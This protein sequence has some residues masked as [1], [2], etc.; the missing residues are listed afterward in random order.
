[1]ISKS[2][3][4]GLLTFSLTLTSCANI[5][6]LSENNT[7]NT[8]SAKTPTAIMNQFVEVE[9]E[10]DMQNI[11]HQ[12]TLV[13]RPAFLRPVN[14]E[15]VQ[16]W[17]KYFS[18]RGK[19]HFERYMK[20][21]E[22][23]RP[24]IEEIFEDYGL[25]RELYFVGLIESGYHLHAKSIASA[26]GPWQFIKST[27]LRYGLKVQHGIDE[28]RNIVKAT[29]AAALFF[30]DLYNIFGSWEL[31]LSAYNAGE[32]GVI[33]RIRGA[34]T[35]D[36]YEL[37]EMKKLPKETRHYV[38]KVLAAMEV[39]NNHKKYGV[40]HPNITSTF[41]KNTDV[42]KIRQSVDV[43]W[44]SNKLGVDLNTFKELNP[45]ILSSAIPYIPKHGISIRIPKGK[46]ST[47]LASMKTYKERQND[48]IGTYKI[49]SGDNLIEIAR[50]FN[51]SVGELK[52]LNQM[53]RNTIYTGQKLRVPSSV[54]SQ[55]SIDQDTTE[56]EKYK[57]K[58][59][60]NLYSIAR[61]YHTSLSEILKLNGTRNKNIFIGQTIKVPKIDRTYYIVKQGD[62]LEKIAKHHG[63]SVQ[64]I[65][66]LNTMNNSRI[67][68][69]QRLIVKLN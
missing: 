66:N 24:L 18:T 64:Q 17:I 39:Y 3:L 19:G 60:D 57:V 47:L 51:I 45:E 53:S 42:V 40:T 63:V 33:R 61:R 35:R 36:F 14:N 10:K 4:S 22:K 68:P 67:F 7:R 55:N 48:N 49:K 2:K 37:S 58:R 15:V 11:L 34:K 25:P 30:Q 20:N 65:K 38:P 31:A 13:E 6:T 28:R 54:A 43:K 9:R 16:M 59:G 52:M 12:K 50:K 69:G 27:G 29:K 1:M 21:G 23:Y 46:E 41:Y 5:R 26:V 32:Y 8:A 44:L 56:F 62:F